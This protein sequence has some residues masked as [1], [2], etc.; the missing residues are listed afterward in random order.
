[1]PKWPPVA[2]VHVAHLLHGQTRKFHSEQAMKTTG[3]IASSAMNGLLA[4][5]RLGGLDADTVSARI[6]LGSNALFA[7]SDF[8]PLAAFTS[9]LE[10]ASEETNDPI[11]G[12]KLGKEFEFQA[13]GSLA[14]LFLTAPTLKEGLTQ[15]SR[16]FPALQS[17]SR[18]ALVVENDVARFS[19]SIH[20]NTVRHKTQ[21]ADFTESLLNTMLAATIGEDW[22]PCCIEFE[23]MPG[24]NLAL[25]RS[26]LACPLSFGRRENAIVF[27]KKFL[28]R[29]IGA[30]GDEHRH[31]QIAC[32]L[33]DLLYRREKRLDLVAALKAWIA[34]A[35]CQHAS[36]DID[37][38]AGDFGMSLRS[39]QRKL[40]ENGVNYAD[41]RNMV[42]M[43]I[44]KSLLANTRLPISV[45][46]EQLGYSELSAFARS[47]R[48]LTGFTPARFRQKSRNYTDVLKE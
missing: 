16:H 6:G 3:I 11:F 20:D 15:F 7:E 40:A 26:Q 9:A 17:N 29:P 14:A 42:R 35:L 10:V 38:A 31:L 45:I 1:M 25:Y 34:A 47:F 30:G 44:A 46:A 21:D 39:F 4:S 28:D 27:P 8:M 33:S 5:I 41:L 2:S 12:L 18:S 19:Y 23:H 32:E 48:H 43:E 13:I 36:I 24:D 37:H 22:K